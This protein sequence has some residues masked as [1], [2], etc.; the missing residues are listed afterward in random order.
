M[1]KAAVAMLVTL[2]AAAPAFAD[3]DP[4]AEAR[5][6]AARKAAAAQAAQ[7]KAEGDKAAA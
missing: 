1:R 4:A 5:D 3:W 7:R 6:E 2:L